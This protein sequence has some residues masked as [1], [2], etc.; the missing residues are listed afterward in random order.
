M[1]QRVDQFCDRLREQLNAI[2]GRIQ[3]VKTDV[4]ALPAKAEKALRDKRDEAR[5]KVEAQK[6][7][8][9]KARADLKVWGEQKVAETKEAIS[10]WKTKR[11]TRKL[12][13]RADRSEAYAEA[14]V[15]LALASIDEAEEAI[16][17]AV[18]ARKDADAAQ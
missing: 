17:D 8:V 13:A 1:S 14:A 4:Q 7:R 5:T 6:E 15:V 11:E 10:E 9:E 3:S 16:L 12:Q 18:A 2:E